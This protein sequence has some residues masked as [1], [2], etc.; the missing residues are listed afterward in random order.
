MKNQLKAMIVHKCFFF[1]KRIGSKEN[2]LSIDEL[3]EELSLRYE[4]FLIKAETAKLND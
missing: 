1:E 4:R 2:Q 3:N